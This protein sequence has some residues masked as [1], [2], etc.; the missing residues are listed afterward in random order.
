[1]GP[2]RGGGPVRSGLC[3]TTSASAQPQSKGLLAGP[4]QAGCPL[5]PPIFTAV[6][7]S[8]PEKAEGWL[9]V[10]TCREP[11]SCP[12]PSRGGREWVVLRKTLAPI[13]RWG[14]TDKVLM[15]DPGRAGRPKRLLG[16]TKWSDGHVPGILHQATDICQ[17]GSLMLNGGLVFCCRI[18]S[19]KII[20]ETGVRAEGKTDTISEVFV[21]VNH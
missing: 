21:I 15:N 8:G 16:Y 12:P 3:F 20:Q 6:D 11:A 10:A 13:F 14:A 2:A 19:K 1:L 18:F 4:V 5:P 7:G 17:T 9:P